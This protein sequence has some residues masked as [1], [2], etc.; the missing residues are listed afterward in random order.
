V[1]QSGIVVEFADA[2]YY[3]GGDL[4]TKTDVTLTR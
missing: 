3:N 2:P 4:V 1:K